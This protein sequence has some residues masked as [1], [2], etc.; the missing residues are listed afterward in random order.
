MSGLAAKRVCDSKSEN[1]QLVLSEHMNG[2][3]RLFGGQLVEWIDILAGVVA[4]RHSNRNVTTATIDNL[5]FKHP[6]HVNDVVVLIGRITFVGKTS[7]EVRV[8]TYIEDLAGD[9][10]LINVAYLVLVALDDEEL[11]VE[12]PK[13][14]LETEEE[15]SEWEAAAKRRQLRKQR[16]IEQY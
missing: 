6:A 15:K 4:R 8:D 2:Y 13:L 5:Q 9:K 14:L 16:R 3:N 12:V 7:M 1:V 10:E 11:P